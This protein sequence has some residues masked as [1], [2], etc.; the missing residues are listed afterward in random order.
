MLDRTLPPP[1]HEADVFDTP[2]P[3]QIQAGQ[4][5][6][7]WL[8]QVDQP[9]VRI[10]LVWPA[11]RWY[12]PKP[13]VSHFLAT[14]LDKGTRKHSALEIAEH[15][16]YHGSSIEAESGYDYLT[17]TLLSIQSQVSKVLPLLF[18][19]LTDCTFPAE[20]LR[21]ARNI[22]LQNLQVNRQKNSFLASVAMRENLF[23]KNHPYGSRLEEPE[24]D[25]ISVESL[26]E[27]YQQLGRPKIFI[28]GKV[29]EQVI[30]ELSGFFSV[31]QSYIK[32]TP[33]F[34]PVQGERR[35]RIERAESIQTAL[36]L[37]KL[38]INR[39]HPEYACV[40]LANHILGG[41][42]GSRLM[43]NIREEKGLTYGIYSS[44]NPFAHA[45]IHFIAADVNKENR[46]LATSEIIKELKMLQSLE[47]EE[48]T[49]ARNHFLG[50]LQLEVANPFSIMDRFK[51][52]VLMGLPQKFYET[53]ARD[54]KGLELQH[55][56]QVAIL[57]FDASH[58]D[59]VSVG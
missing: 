43:R 6:V 53:L 59:E 52:T 39:Q 31:H 16:E 26:T 50:S 48:L 8:Q 34:N 13:G 1:F 25:A 9:A 27:Y 47:E 35:L 14:L 44:I 28:T 19:I 7:Y 57:H 5:D 15:L 12:E 51:T 36:R 40:V 17:V 32:E 58:F 23:G 41:Y 4:L 10:E 18:E 33:L 20:E 54:I 42:F 24:V 3:Q 56:K 22:Y 38:T 11:G 37:A 49:T 2:A 29:S 45:S 21:L 30:Q 55:L 46:E